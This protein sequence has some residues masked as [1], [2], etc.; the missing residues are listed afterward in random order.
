M[1][2][3]V[4]EGATSSRTNYV[5]LFFSEAVVDLAYLPNF[6][7]SGGVA[8][9]SSTPSA[10]RRRADLE[11]SGMTQGASY[12]VTVA[13]VAPA[14]GAISPVAA[15]SIVDTE[16]ITIGDG[17]LTI[18]YEFNKDGGPFTAGRTPVQI[19]TGDT[20]AQVRDAIIS[21]INGSGGGVVASVNGADIDLVRPGG[22]LGNVT[23]LETVA[24]AS[25]IVSGMAGGVGVTDL[26]LEGIAVFAADF[27]AGDVPSG[28]DD[29][30]TDTASTLKTF[31]FQE[32]GSFPGT[33]DA[34]GVGTVSAVDT[35]TG[36]QND[37]RDFLGSITRQVELVDVPVPL[38]V[39]QT[40]TAVIEAD[41]ELQVTAVADDALEMNV[42]DDDAL[43]LT[44]ECCT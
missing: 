30:P 41:D 37:A 34:Q 3:P 32:G 22:S 18:V 21:A 12:T 16:T 35:K 44:V 1:V 6:S 4:L 31:T 28:A 43:T 13:G 36:A 38:F 27:V 15:S 39:D 8:V 9:L 11:C 40:I 26:G 10:D 17:L 23:I 25:F 20:A 5:T 42:E 7:I 19:F 14:V 29:T 33:F 24:D 2:A